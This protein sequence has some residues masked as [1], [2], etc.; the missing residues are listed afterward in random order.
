MTIIIQVM[1]IF[2]TWMTFSIIISKLFQAYLQAVLNKP[3]TM[4][5]TYRHL[6]TI[7][8]NHLICMDCS[9]NKRRLPTLQRRLPTLHWL[10]ILQA[11][12]LQ[13]RTFLESVSM[14]VCL[15]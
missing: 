2:K 7:T 14:I 4:L 1:T 8:T 15:N 11:L 5:T 6:K 13:V 12:L 10:T 3:L 9:T